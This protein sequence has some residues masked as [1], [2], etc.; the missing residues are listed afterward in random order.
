MGAFKS[1][2]VKKNVR[3]TQAQVFIDYINGMCSLYEL[4]FSETR[5]LEKTMTKEEIHSYGFLTLEESRLESLEHV[6]STY[7]KDEGR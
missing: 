4:C 7:P 5:K 1:R 3:L 6:R 2:V